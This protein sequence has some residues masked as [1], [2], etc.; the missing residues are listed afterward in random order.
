[1]MWCTNSFPLFPKFSSVF[2]MYCTV[3][4]IPIHFAW[5]HHRALKLMHSVLLHFRCFFLLFS[6]HTRLFRFAWTQ[7]HSVQCIFFFSISI[8]WPVGWWMASYFTFWFFFLPLKLYKNWKYS[9]CTPFTSTRFF[10]IICLFIVF[11]TKFI[12]CS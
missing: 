6:A 9:T 4:S 2:C 11:N 3:N 1:M 8:V 10:S 12:T 5:Q 7:N